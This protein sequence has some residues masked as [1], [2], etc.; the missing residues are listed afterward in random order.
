MSTVFDIARL[1]SVK[2]IGKIIIVSPPKRRDLMFK[3]RREAI[4]VL[5]RSVDRRGFDE[6]A[7]ADA[8]A[9]IRIRNLPKKTNEDK[10]VREINRLTFDPRNRENGWQ[11]IAMM[12]T[13]RRIYQNYTQDNI[14]FAWALFWGMKVE[15]LAHV[16]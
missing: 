11:G 15:D 7:W 1:K 3:F 6:D 16:V 10:M 12:E 5:D 13:S 2:P 9:S 8:F 4:R 14:D